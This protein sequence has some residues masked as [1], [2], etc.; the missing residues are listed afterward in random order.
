MG[1]VVDVL[2]AVLFGLG[3]L[4]IFRMWNLISG[5]TQ[6]EDAARENSLK[7]SNAVLPLLFFAAAI[8]A[9]ILF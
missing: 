3:V 6:G 5:Y 2:V 9:K 4:C 8:V 1:T 7:R